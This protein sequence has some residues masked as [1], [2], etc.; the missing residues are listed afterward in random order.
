MYMKMR[1]FVILFMKCGTISSIHTL[2]GRTL[3]FFGWKHNSFVEKLCYSS[4]AKIFEA[5]YTEY[6][7]WGV[8]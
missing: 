7:A 2:T 4:I 8:F 5:R 3:V 1:R 6:I